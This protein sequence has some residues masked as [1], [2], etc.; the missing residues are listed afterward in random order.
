MSMITAYNVCCN[1]L[2]YYISLN[3]KLRQKYN[4]SIN[5]TNFSLN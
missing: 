5:K 1:Y 4:F 2:I 3:T